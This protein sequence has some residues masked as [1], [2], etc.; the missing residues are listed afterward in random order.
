[1]N[2]AL[3][4]CGSIAAYKS[5]EL[6]RFL[7]KAGAD[8]RVILTKSAVNFVTSLS[9]QTLSTNDVYID[10]FVLSKGIK[11]L[12]LSEWADMLVIAPATAN[13][14]GKAVSGIGDDLLSTAILSFQ[15]PVLF[16]PAMDSGM[17]QNKVV[18]S[19]VKR[20]IHLGHH[21]V[22]PTTGI[23]A[24]GKIGKGRFP[25]VAI[26]YKKILTI[27]GEY[28]S[29]AGKR[30]LITGGRTEE[31]LD[32]VRVITNRSSGRMAM[33]LCD[34]VVCRDGE[35]K[36][37]F[38]EVS[39]P[40]PGEMDISRVRTSDEMLRELKKHLSWCDCLI[41]AAA[42]GDY[43]PCSKSLAKIHSQKIKLDFEKSRDLLKAIAADKGKMVVV[44]FSLE[45]K[46]QL[47]R[48]RQKLVSKGLNFIVANA[49]SA[50]ASDKTEAMI[51]K[52]AGKTIDVGS[53]SKWQLAHKI[54]DECMIEMQ[55]RRIIKK[56]R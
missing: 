8:V 22:E 2:I 19:N 17:W 35:V 38:G 27:L 42:V 13:I 3:G 48:A 6:I 53:V 39:I 10:Q 31:D 20:L 40:I 47:K 56:R 32:S 43:K 28:R 18:E 49:V 14:I 7:K 23:L 24:S 37:I 25:S 51:L 1:L 4:I 45:I 34:A 16:V 52:K 33:E 54:L 5:L 21:F 44:G 12:A 41:M 55:K 15:K 50:L 11:H 36:G 30:F 26:I 29:L 9:C 46:D